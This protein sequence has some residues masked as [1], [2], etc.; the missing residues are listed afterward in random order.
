M[1]FLLD[2][3]VYIVAIHNN[4]L[5]FFSEYMVYNHVFLV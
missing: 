2:I 1:Q 3:R 5:I 4:F